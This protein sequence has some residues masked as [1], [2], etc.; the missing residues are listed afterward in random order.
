[1][2]AEDF[3]LHTA[4]D[5][6]AIVVVLGCERCNRWTRV[7]NYVEGGRYPYHKHDCP[8]RDEYMF[9]RRAK[10][11]PREFAD[12]YPYGQRILELYEP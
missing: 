9:S 2:S 1:M 12:T 6:T 5:G 7:A 4:A 8:D 3:R 10:I 11:D